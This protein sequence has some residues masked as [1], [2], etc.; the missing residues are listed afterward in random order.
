MDARSWS[1]METLNVS[2]N[3]TSKTKSPGRCVLYSGPLLSRA[4]RLRS[5]FR[6]KQFGYRLYGRTLMMRFARVL[7]TL[8]AIGVAGAAT[9][10]A[11]V[12]TSSAPSKLYLAVDA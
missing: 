7:M 2:Q 12:A 3:T 10:H 5:S 1:F 9:A 6:D 8:L 11:Q 4:V